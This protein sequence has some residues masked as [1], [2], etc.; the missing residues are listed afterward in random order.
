MPVLAVGTPYP[1]AYSQRVAAAARRAV[2]AA[3]RLDV[4]LYRRTNGRVGCVD[5]RLEEACPASAGRPGATAIFGRGTRWQM[6]PRRSSRTTHDG[7]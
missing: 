5:R 3:T 4:W 1:W 2:Q 6:A 7:R